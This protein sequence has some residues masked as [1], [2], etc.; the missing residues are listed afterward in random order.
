MRGTHT[1]PLHLL[2]F[3]HL[4]TQQISIVLLRTIRTCLPRFLSN[5]FPVIQKQ[6]YA[7]WKHVLKNGLPRQSCC[8]VNI[9]YNHGMFFAVIFSWTLC[10]LLKTLWSKSIFV[11]RIRVRSNSKHC[12]I[13]FHVI[14]SWA[15]TIQ[16][17]KSTTDSVSKPLSKQNMYHTTFVY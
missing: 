17:L 13:C 2:I 15:P 14:D 11:F 9:Q 3:V 10:F 16:Y 4:E 12:W 7:L 6:F 1:K 5:I 8:N